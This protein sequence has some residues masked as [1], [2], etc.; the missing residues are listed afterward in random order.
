MQMLVLIQQLMIFAQF[1]HPNF[2]LFKF[3]YLKPLKEHLEHLK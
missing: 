2:D 1:I 3:I